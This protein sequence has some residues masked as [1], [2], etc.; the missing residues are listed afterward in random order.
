MATNLFTNGNES[1]ILVTQMATNKQTN[2]N[3]LLVAIRLT[4]VAIRVYL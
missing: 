2:G 1:K 4:F 3:E